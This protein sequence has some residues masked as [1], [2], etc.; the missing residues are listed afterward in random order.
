MANEPVVPRFGTLAPTLVENGYEPVPLYYGEKN[1][2]AGKEWQNFKYQDS[3]CSRFASAGTG[4]LCGRVIGLDIDVRR[5]DLAEYL[6]HRAEEI[7]GPAPRRIGQPPKVLRMLEAS[8]PFPKMSTR[9]FRFPEDQPEDKSHRVEI[10]AKGQQFVAFNKHPDT[11]QAYVWNGAGDPLTVPIGLLPSITEEQARAF[12]HEADEFLSRHGRPVGRLAAADEE[13]RYHEAN[14]S[15]KAKDTKLLREALTSIPNDELEFDD[16]IRM[17]YAVKGALGVDGVEDFMRWSSKAAKDDPQNTEKEYLAARPTKLG[18][19][20]VYY[21]AA[22]SGWARHPPPASALPPVEELEDISDWPDPINIL[23]EL[24]APAF[25]PSEA[26]SVLSNYA[27]CY[28]EQ[29]GIDFGIALLSAVVAAAAAIPDQLQVLASSASNWFA[30][31]RLWG[32][33]IAAP[34]AGKTPAQREMIKPL[35]K[36]HEALNDAW[37]QQVAAIEATDQE[38]QPKQPKPPKPRAVVGDA[39]LEALSDV[40]CENE[41]GVLIATDEFDAWIGAMDQYKSGGIGK[42][43]GEWLRLFDGGPHSI[44]RVKRGSIFIPNWGVSIL[45]ATTPAAMGRLTKHLP[46]DGLIQRFIIV[47]AQRQTIIDLEADLGEIQG[48][49]GAYVETISRLW[50]LNVKKDR[51]VKLSGDARIR[52]GQWRR[53]NLKLQEALGALDSAIEGHIAKYPTLALRLALTFHCA[54]VANYPEGARDPTAWPISVETLDLAF[55]FLRRAS[56]HALTLYLSRKGGS[57][58]YDLAKS[59]GRWVLTVA[60]DEPKD[61]ERRDLLR[62]VAAFKN[63]PEYQ[64]GAAM[65]L[66]VDSGWLR[67]ADGGYQKAHPTR[68]TLSPR[69]AK[70]F[71]QLA[72]REVEFRAIARERLAESVDERREQQ[73]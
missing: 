41:R 58:V 8:V 47:L 48:E 16:W 64:Q 3:D 42:D 30:Q 71:A 55:R 28:A 39:T 59:V 5:A 68:Y 29:T 54:I 66:L 53:D 10:L 15:Q 13:L 31:P 22:Q 70:K 4:I 46:E 34:G 52:F 61:I 2:C 73:P 63:A 12:I 21:L 57:Q 62:R 38:G 9:G 43:R 7:F 35:W 50:T 17:V 26:P 32:L 24:A 19:G 37:R 14:E 20:T 23:G 25:L 56:Q 65:R 6:D 40:L 49:R 11:G 1:P 67:E 69:L 27:R 51:V 44:E 45:T 33:V 18:A 72:I 36:I 60:A